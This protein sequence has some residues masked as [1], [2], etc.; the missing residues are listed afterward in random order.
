MIVFL[1]FL[2]IEIALSLKWSP[3]YFNNGLKLYKKKAMNTGLLAERLDEVINLLAKNSNKKCITLPMQFR[4]L[5]KNSIMF[6]ENMANSSFIRYTPLMHGKIIIN[7]SSIKVIGIANWFP[8]TF[9]CFWYSQMIPYEGLKTSSHMAFLVFPL[10]L[11]GLI[12]F[13]QR[14]KYNKIITSLT[15]LTL[16]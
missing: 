1:L 13:I 5:D 16:S 10:I 7:D 2:V 3:F 6:R 9:L 15:E 11:F 8:I 4:K 12:Y 14:K